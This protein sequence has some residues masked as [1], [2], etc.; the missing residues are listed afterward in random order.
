MAELCAQIAAVSLEKAEYAPATRRSAHQHLRCSPST[1]VMPASAASVD[2]RRERNVH[3]PRS[4]E[5]EHGHNSCTTQV[6]GAVFKPRGGEFGA[7][8]SV[9]RKHERDRDVGWILA[10][11]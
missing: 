2:W 3:V 5:V 4:N 7:R 11:R 8:C 1:A 10:R 9:R 6:C